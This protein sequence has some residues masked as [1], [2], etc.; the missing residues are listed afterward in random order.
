MPLNAVKSDNAFSFHAKT[1]V[2]GLNCPLERHSSQ[3]GKV[4]WIVKVLVFS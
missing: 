2:R 4:N 1:D 3:F